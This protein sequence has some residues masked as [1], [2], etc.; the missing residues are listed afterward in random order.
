MTLTQDQILTAQDLAVR[1][2]N[3]A[4]LHAAWA[5]LG[6][7]RRYAFQ[8]ATEGQ[9]SAGESACAAALGLV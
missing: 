3:T 1:T 6:Y 5:A 8:L 2:S 9:R 4:L 7:D